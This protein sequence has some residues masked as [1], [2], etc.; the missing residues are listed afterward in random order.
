MWNDAVGVGSASVVGKDDDVDTV[1]RER[2]VHGLKTAYRSIVPEVRMSVQRSAE[3]TKRVCAIGLRKRS[4]REHFMQRRLRKDSG[5]AYG[6][7][8]LLEIRYG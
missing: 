1:V 6:L 7:V 4:G 3:P 2:R 8:P 5:L